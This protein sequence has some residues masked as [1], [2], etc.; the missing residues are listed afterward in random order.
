PRWFRYAG[1]EPQLEILDG[2]LGI[3]EAMLEQ[4]W[5]Q[6]RGES[7]FVTVVV[8]EQ[9]ESASLWAQARHPS[10]LALK[11]RLLTEPGGVIADVPPVAGHRAPLPD[12]L[13]VRVLVS[14]VNAMAMR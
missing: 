1:G 5:R 3:S 10:E 2:G 9:F 13:V 6:P 4:V 12:R 8:A 14:A 7:D 11:F